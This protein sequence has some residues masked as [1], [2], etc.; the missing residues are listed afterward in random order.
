MESSA[1][2]GNGDWRCHLAAHG[3]SSWRLT[4]SIPPPATPN[5]KIANRNRSID[6]LVSIRRINQC[7]TNV[8]YFHL[9][10]TGFSTCRTTVRIW[11]YSA[12]SPGILAATCSAATSSKPT[13]RCRVS[14]I[15]PPLPPT[16]GAIY[17]PPIGQLDGDTCA[18]GP[19]MPD[20]TVYL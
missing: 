4:E 2:L 5:K 11:R 16:G 10:L 14:T 1:C 19:M 18:H 15:I 8:V 3:G 17:R 12:T 20:A 6:Q 13:K 7:E 9:E